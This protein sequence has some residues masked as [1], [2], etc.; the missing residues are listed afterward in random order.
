MSANAMPNTTNLPTREPTLGFVE[1]EVLFAVPMKS[2]RHDS[3][4]RIENNIKS[5][6]FAR[7]DE[8]PSWSF[9]CELEPAPR[10]EFDA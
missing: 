9:F 8:T 3:G 2:P 1:T 5:L 7:I 6:G 4:T 10:R